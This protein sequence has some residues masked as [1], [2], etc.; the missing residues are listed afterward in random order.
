MFTGVIN[1]TVRVT[2]C[3]GP[4]KL[5]CVVTERMTGLTV[6][7][8]RSQFIPCKPYG[9]RTIGHG[10]L[11]VLLHRHVAAVKWL[12]KYIKAGQFALIIRILPSST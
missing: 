7:S 6:S 3:P 1:L 12:K 4:L 2:E 5:Y 9:S 10:G 11:S 8:T